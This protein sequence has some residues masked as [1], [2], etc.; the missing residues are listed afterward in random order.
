MNANFKADLKA[1][2]LLLV[3]SALAIVGV[4]VAE[5]V[6]GGFKHVVDFTTLWIFDAAL[7]LI[8]VG[9]GIYCINQVKKGGADNQYSYATWVGALLNVLF[10]AI[11]CAT[12][13]NAIR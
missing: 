6:S 5:F 3:F 1:N 9:S 10:V 2:I 12:A 13:A 8:S 4:H 11:Y 7:A